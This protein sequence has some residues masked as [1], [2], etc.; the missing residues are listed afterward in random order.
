M[1]ALPLLGLL[2]G[3]YLFLRILCGI[4]HILIDLV[5]LGALGFCVLMLFKQ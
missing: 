4:T 5:F 1:S 3:F 2:I